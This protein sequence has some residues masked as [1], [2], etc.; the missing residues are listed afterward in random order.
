MDITALPELLV[1]KC[2][3]HRV[4]Y[5]THV[6]NIYANSVSFPIT[7]SACYHDF[8]PYFDLLGIDYGDAVYKGRSSTSASK[9]QAILSASALL[10]G[11]SRSSP[12][13]LFYQRLPTLAPHSLALQVKA[14][15]L[16]RTGLSC[17]LWPT[18][19]QGLLYLI[20]FAA[21][22]LFVSV[23]GSGPLGCPSDADFYGSI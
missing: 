8:V 3:K 22:P 1:Y 18:L 21:W 17:W 2:L 20:S 14:F 16:I 6:S 15:F 11:S 12:T 4:L 13:S 9:L 7:S 5:L 23:F 19:P 10:I